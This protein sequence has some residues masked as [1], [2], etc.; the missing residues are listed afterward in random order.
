MRAIELTPQTAEHSSPG[1]GDRV[2]RRPKPRHRQAA[3]A[4]DTP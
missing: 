4:T 2:T 3:G 1:C